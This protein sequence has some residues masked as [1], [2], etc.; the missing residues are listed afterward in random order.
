MFER[1]TPGLFLV[2]MLRALRLRCPCCGE[3]RLFEPVLRVRALR[4]WFAPLDGC[5]RC[6]YPYEREAG[7]YLMAI[8]AINYGC[9]SVL[10]IILYLWLEWQYDL[11]IKTLLAAVLIPICLFNILFARHAKALFLAV[12]L[13]FDPHERGDD[14]G[15]GNVPVPHVPVA[16][17]HPAPT[18]KDK[19]SP[20][21]HV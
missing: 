13:F 14:D 1:R 17:P 11:P 5:P 9:G 15:R 12:D 20:L 4:D 16:P 2:Y 19:P 18:P 3:K 10:G 21:A 8:W 6:G 7:Y